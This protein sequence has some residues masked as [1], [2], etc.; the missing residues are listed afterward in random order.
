LADREEISLGL[1][2]G[3]SYAAITARLGKATSTVS[4]EVAGSG[5]RR[6]YRA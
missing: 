4:R 2:S 6:E 5:G 3:H 1:R